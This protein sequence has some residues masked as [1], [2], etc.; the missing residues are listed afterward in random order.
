MFQVVDGCFGGE[1]TQDMKAKGGREFKSGQHQNF[2]EQ[3]T[4]F[5][6]ETLFVWMHPA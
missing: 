6:Q 3:A 2:T 1:D 5:V 4:V